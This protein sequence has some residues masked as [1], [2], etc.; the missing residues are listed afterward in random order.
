MGSRSRGRLFDGFGTFPAT[1]HVAGGGIFHVEKV[2]RQESDPRV[3]QSGH[4]AKMLERRYEMLC[5]N[6]RRYLGNK[7]M[8]NVVDQSEGY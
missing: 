8:L 2:H 3:I 6:I 1:F 7:E 4:S 5:E